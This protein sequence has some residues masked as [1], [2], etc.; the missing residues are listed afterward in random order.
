[1]YHPLCSYHPAH[2]KVDRNLFGHFSQCHCLL[3]IPVCLTNSGPMSHWDEYYDFNKEFLLKNK[4]KKKWRIN[5]Y[6]RPFHIYVFINWNLFTIFSIVNVRSL[7]CTQ[8][9]YLL[10]SCFKCQHLRAV[11]FA[12]LLPHLFTKACNGIQ[13]Q[14]WTVFFLV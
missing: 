3:D 6:W 14:E 11:L 10:W 1:M 2:K 13:K 8:H 12:L 4:Q 9:H 7:A 5:L